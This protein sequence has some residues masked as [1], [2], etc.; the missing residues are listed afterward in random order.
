M[1]P[2]EYDHFARM[3]GEARVAQQVK[4]LI[5]QLR[6]SLIRVRRNQYIFNKRQQRARRAP[7]GDR[8]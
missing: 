3:K 1:T 8:V 7:G 4:E 5:A 6:A 2:R